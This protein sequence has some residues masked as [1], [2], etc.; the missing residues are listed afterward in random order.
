MSKLRSLFLF[1]QFSDDEDFQII[2]G[3]AACRNSEIARQ[4]ECFEYAVTAAAILEGLGDIL[5][6]VLFLIVGGI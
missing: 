1:R 2:A 4:M 3:L 6:E 5:F